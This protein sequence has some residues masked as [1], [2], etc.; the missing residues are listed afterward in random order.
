MKVSCVLP[1]RTSGQQARNAIVPF[2]CPRKNRNNER[3]GFDVF[4]ISYGYL[5]KETYVITQC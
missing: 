5:R 3:Q 4:V 1:I 2:K